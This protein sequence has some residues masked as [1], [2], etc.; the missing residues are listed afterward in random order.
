MRQLQ[1]STMTLNAKHEYHKNEFN[2]CKGKAV[3]VKE[4]KEKLSL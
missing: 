4:A 2:K 1:I 3:L